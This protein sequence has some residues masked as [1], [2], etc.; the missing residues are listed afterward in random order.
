MDKE[1]LKKILFMLNIREL[2]IK[3]GLTQQQLADKIG[4]G[5]RSTI[6]KIETGKRKVSKFELNSFANFFQISKKILK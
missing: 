5:D 3:K 4:L 1:I 2:R 6:C